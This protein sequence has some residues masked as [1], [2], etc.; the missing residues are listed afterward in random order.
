MGQELPPQQDLRREQIKKKM[1]Q[2][3]IFP[4]SECF[5]KQLW[6][7]HANTAGPPL[8]SE[9]TAGLCAAR[10]ARAKF[11]FRAFTTKISTAHPTNIP[12]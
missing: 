3:P 12:L 11:H 1:L 6:K 5:P 2:Q 9:L 4:M 10:I 7:S 8:L